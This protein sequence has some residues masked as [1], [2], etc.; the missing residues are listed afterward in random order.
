MTDPVVDA[1]LP[2]AAVVGRRSRL[3]AAG[4]ARLPAWAGQ[5]ARFLAVGGLAFVLDWGVLQLMLRTGSGPYAGRVVSMAG[6]MVFA[7]WLNRHVTFRTPA[8]PSWPEFC[9]YVANS[10]AGAAINYAIYSAAV[11]MGAPVVAGL[12]LGTGIAAVFNFF[13]YRAI[14]G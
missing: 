2:P 12:I 14:L 1:E 3:F 4:G 11:A 9:A 13:R 5:V 6:G 7:W 8:P 10:L